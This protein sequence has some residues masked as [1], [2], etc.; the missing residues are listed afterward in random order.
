SETQFLDKL[1]G[2]VN[3]HVEGV[4]SFLTAVA[5]GNGSI[6]DPPW[7]G[8]ELLYKFQA[9]S[10][11]LEIKNDRLLSERVLQDMLRAGCSL[12]IHLAL[13]VE[14]VVGEEYAIDLSPL[15]PLLTSGDLPVTAKR[16]KLKLESFDRGTGVGVLRGP[17]RFEERGERQGMD[18]TAAYEG[19]CVLRV[20]PA[21]ARI[22]DV[23]FKSTID[24]SAAQKEA[25]V[26]MAGK[27]TY[28][29][30]LET[31]LGDAVAKASGRKPAFRDR[32]RPAN[33][34]GVKLTLPSYF[35]GI[36]LG[37]RQQFLRT[38]DASKGRAVILFEL[39]AE[40]SANPKSYF[41][42]LGAALK[43]SNPKIRSIKVKCSLGPGMA[44]TLD[45]VHQEKTWRVRSEFY[46][47]GKAGWLVYKLMAE[48]KCFAAA[49]KDFIKARGTL[50]SAR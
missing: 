37:T 9:D 44:Y 23:S 4:R 17:A 41:D 32:P 30:S 49:E 5:M 10:T 14:A 46:P 8:V 43:K 27:G 50:Q 36:R 25:S 2:D 7:S 19:E 33:D 48:P 42:A 31:A 35:E 16:T 39:V 21:D 34:L 45:S 29:M 12:G 20:N 26:K 28:S 3:G 47:L 6:E 40:S 24:F 15:A 38:I 11:A 18:A 22:L 13:P 1:S